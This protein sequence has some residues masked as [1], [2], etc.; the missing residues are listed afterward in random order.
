MLKRAA[1]FFA[2]TLI[3]ATTLF[4]QSSNVDRSWADRLNDDVYIV[5]RIDND[6]TKSGVF[7]RRPS[8][9]KNSNWCVFV[10]PREQVY[11]LTLI[12]RS[13]HELF[14]DGRKVEDSLIWKHTAEFKPYLEKFWR[15]REIEDESAELERQIKPIDRKMEEIQKEIEKLEQANEKL[16]R[17]SSSFAESKS[18]DAKLNRL[19]EIERDLELQIESLSKSQETLSKEQESL[20]LDKETD[21]V[22]SRMIADLKALGAIKSSSNL[23]FKL[24]NTQF[25]INGKQAS[26]EIYQLMKDRYVV[27]TSGENGFLYRW[28]GKI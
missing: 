11:K 16:E 20:Q 7:G 10:G 8:D 26:P 1:R 9:V 18:I 21:R 13:I 17:G 6:G 4:S 2:L 24:S 12:D 27:E 23:R 22:L 14:I 5:G 15:D 28:K 19:S 25:I 3:A